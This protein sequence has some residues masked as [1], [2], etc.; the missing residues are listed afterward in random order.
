VFLFFLESFFKFRLLSPGTEY[1]LKVRSIA[2]ALV[3]ECLV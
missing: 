1:N 2:Q 3:L